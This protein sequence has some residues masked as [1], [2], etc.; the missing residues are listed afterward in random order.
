MSLTDRQI[1]GLVVLYAH[2]DHST[3]KV[4]ASQSQL[5]RASSLK[6]TTWQDSVI[7]ALV[8]LGLVSTAMETRGHYR[9]MAYTL[10]PE[11]LALA[12]TLPVP[13]GSSHSETARSGS[14]V[15]SSRVVSG[16]SPGRLSSSSSSFW[17][18]NKKE[19]KT[20][21]TRDDPPGSS[22]RP[23]DDPEPSRAVLAETLKE[24]VETIRELHETIRSLATQQG[25]V[26]PKC[27]CGKDKTLKTNTKDGSKF[28]A[29]PLFKKCPH[30]S[31]EP[32]GAQK[33]A[34]LA[35]KT[36][37]DAPKAPVKFVPRPRTA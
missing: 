23:G 2:R 37:Q 3:G 16:S 18:Q 21:T 32:T 28:W 11:G 19:E 14:S 7:P 36:R 20:E 12:P 5:L 26:S 17:D 25:L 30:Y 13:S 29:C 27:E 34:A 22:T 10:T 15:G 8:A 24:A 33:A 31:K 1:R 6:A 9:A 35:E 4:M